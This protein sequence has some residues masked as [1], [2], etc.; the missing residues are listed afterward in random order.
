[1]HAEARCATEILIEKRLERDLVRNAILSHTP[2][3][4][5]NLRTHRLEVPREELLGGRMCK[6]LPINLETGL[7]EAAYKQV[8]LTG[9]RSLQSCR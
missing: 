4:A 8:A 2:K 7:F 1:M 3:G 6:L 5:H 9:N